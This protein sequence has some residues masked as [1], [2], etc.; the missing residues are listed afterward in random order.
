MEKKIRKFSGNSLR[1][2][3][4][5]NRLLSGEPQRGQKGKLH[6]PCALKGSMEEKTPWRSSCPAAVTK[7]VGSC[8]QWA[9]RQH[10]CHRDTTAVTSTAP[11]SQPSRRNP[12][13][14]LGCRLAAHWGP[15]AAAFSAASH[16][17]LNSMTWSYRS[18]ITLFLP[19]LKQESH[20]CPVLLLYKVYYHGY[21]E[22]GIGW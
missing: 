22:A 5:T 8:Q 20:L 6:E 16:T 4:A 17:P 19:P 18:K 9:T 15:G 11:Q 1:I 12:R 2:F 7:A 13:H 21:V 10:L 3:P 14:P